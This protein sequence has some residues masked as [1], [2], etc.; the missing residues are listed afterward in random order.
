MT[1]GKPHFRKSPGSHCVPLI[2]G[3]M[4]QPHRLGCKSYVSGEGRSAVWRNL[5]PGKSSI[6][7]QFWMP[8]SALSQQA[9]ARSEMPRAGFSHITGQTNER[10]R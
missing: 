4:V 9:L 10:S 5:A 6:S 3:R 8:L 2:E 7:P 1:H